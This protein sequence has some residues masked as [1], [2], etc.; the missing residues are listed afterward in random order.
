MI[1]LDEQLNDKRIIS[2]VEHWYEGQVAVIQELHPG[3]V[4]K[5]DA[6]PMLLLEK[7]DPTF[8]TIN[9]DDFWQ[10]TPPNDGY[11]VICLKLRSNEK[12]KVGELVREVLGMPQYD[13][14]QKRMGKVIS[15]NHGHVTHYP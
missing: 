14:K 8:V 7:K 1:V 4:I 5:D 15:L 13:T 12:L 9:Y 11:C 10:I 2:A 6:V 3:T